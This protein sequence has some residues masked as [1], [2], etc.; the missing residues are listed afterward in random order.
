MTRSGKTK[1]MNKVI[2]L[3]SAIALAACANTESS[4][5]ESSDYQQI[6]FSSKTATASERAFCE[7]VGGIVRP[8]GMA[9]FDHCIQNLPDAG[10]ACTDAKECLGRC[11]IPSDQEAPDSG[12]S[13]SGV[14]EATDEHFG[15]TALVNDGKYEGTL[16]VD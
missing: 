11:A 3:A 2:L 6:N 1:A 16:C 13:S 9:Q 5:A 8:A 14:C 7:S 15:C 12:A 10:K 4:D